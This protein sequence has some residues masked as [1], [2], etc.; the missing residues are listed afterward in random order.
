MNIKRLLKSVL[1]L[2]GTKI[3]THL[4]AVVKKFKDVN[5][6]PV[7]DKPTAGEL[8]ITH[9]TLM[10]ILKETAVFKKQTGNRLTCCR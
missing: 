1:K 7:C 6:K 2:P 3:K 10:N 5:K 8:K 4:K 9:D